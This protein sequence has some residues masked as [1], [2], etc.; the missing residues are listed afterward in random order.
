MLSYII[1]NLWLVWC[2]HGRVEGKTR[3]HTIRTLLM[4]QIV[5]LAVAVI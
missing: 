2:P 4:K 1:P 5:E 3:T